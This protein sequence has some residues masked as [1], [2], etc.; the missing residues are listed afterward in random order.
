[1]LELGQ[2]LLQASV[3]SGLYPEI[4]N[5]HPVEIQ[6]VFSGVAVAYGCEHSLVEAGK[7]RRTAR[8][9]LA[10][11]LVWAKSAPFLYGRA[12]NP[13]NY[14]SKPAAMNFAASMFCYNDL[15]LACRA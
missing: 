14:Y 3:V 15:F 7:R 11:K 1:M 9:A 10:E 5:P 8:P 4:P 6:P 2:C 13:V 12:F